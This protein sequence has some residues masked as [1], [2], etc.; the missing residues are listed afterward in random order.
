[1]T[2]HGRAE[3]LR[4]IGAA[5][6]LI[7][8]FLPGPSA[9]ADPSPRGARRAG[10]THVDTVPTV[11]PG[12]IATVPVRLPADE[13]RNPLPYRIRPRPGVR[14]LGET[15]GRSRPVDGRHVVPLTVQVPASREAGS[16]VV[17]TVVLDVPGD[18]DRRRRVRVRVAEERGLELEA[19]VSATRAPP[20]GLLRVPFRLENT[21]NVQ[22]SVRLRARARGVRWQ[23]AY[24][25]GNRA[26][27]PGERW[28]D[29]ARVRVPTRLNEGVAE[30]VEL[31]ASAGSGATAGAD[32]VLRVSSPAAGPFPGMERLPASLFLSTSRI[33]LDGSG[34]AP[35]VVGSLDASGRIGGGLRL[36]LFGRRRPNREAPDGVRHFLTGPTARAALSGDGWEVAA[37]DVYGDRGPIAGVAFNGRGVRGRWNGGGW[38]G[39]LLLAAPAGGSTFVRDG[40][41]I[42]GFLDRETPHGTVGLSAAWKEERLLPGG[43]PF[44]A[45]SAGLRYETR[46]GPGDS[47]LQLGGGWMQLTRG[48]SVTAQGPSAEATL[49]IGG[50]SGQAWARASRVPG[51]W[52]TAGFRGDQLRIGGRYRAAT[53]LHLLGHF[54]YAHSPLLGAPGDRSR[55]GVEAG[56][57]VDAGGGELRFAAGLRQERDDASGSWRDLQALDLGASLPLGPFSWTARVETERRIDGADR[58]DDW[59]LRFLRSGLRYSGDDLRA[60]LTVHALDAFRGAGPGRSPWRYSIRGTWRG[61]ALGV[62][63]RVRSDGNPADA[64]NRAS[65]WAR[66]RRDVT[67]RTALVVTVERNVGVRAASDLTL[68][69]DSDDD[70]WS[71][72]IGVQVDLDLPLPIP[73]HHDVTGTVFLDRNGNLRRDPGER[74]V[75]S[76]TLQKGWA[77]VETDSSGGFSIGERSVAERRLRLEPA[78]LPSGLVLP[79][80]V[81]LP[82]SGAVQIP[83]VRPAR[84]EVRLF[85]DQ[86]G[87]GRRDEA[88]RVV[89]GAR[90]EMMSEDARE[91][92]YRQESGIGGSATFG[93]VLPGR[94]RL[95]VRVPGSTF[96]EPVELRRS[97]RLAPGAERALTVPVPAGRDGIP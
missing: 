3:A 1:M 11:E 27:G 89:S 8:L 23:M 53:D 43:S 63:W 71:A 73:R 88:E 35:D 50:E 74:G 94:Y 59:H 90:V 33:H 72:T 62:R 32:V 45:R 60:W 42:T 69:D 25:A 47:H 36:D 24:P 92:H 82:R 22:D 6:T 15:T 58:T 77:R 76:V 86:N 4:A 67:D 14:L 20:G 5:S 21:G 49:R 46:S 55:R 65:G 29:T 57:D 18:D 16:W 93:A 26:L 9:L 39:G 61:D 31:R 75:P 38:D 78:S 37:G 13:A 64:G 81:E 41:R 97:V 52:P 84:L 79:P 54:F 83:L 10:G 87:N 95:T 12:R 19:R 85:R 51:L 44:G 40:H 68:Y 7:L 34:A 28:S 2:G 48:D 91:R 17:A 56:T 80:S 70:G 96:R 30:H 66:V